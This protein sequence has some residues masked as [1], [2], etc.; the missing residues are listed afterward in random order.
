MKNIFLIYGLIL[1]LAI[2]SCKT[3]APDTGETAAEIP[4]IDKTLM[5]TNISPSQDFYQF[6]NGQ[7]LETTEIP[8]D[9]G[10]WGGFDELRKRT[11]ADVLSILAK[12]GESDLANQSSDQRKAAAFSKVGWIPNRSNGSE[13]NLFNHTSN[14]LTRFQM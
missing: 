1:S 14:K 9:R 5:D 3:E 4:G 6:A 12:A 7:W 2:I 10:R 11:D 8:A 13:S